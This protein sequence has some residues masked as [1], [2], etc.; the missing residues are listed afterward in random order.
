MDFKHSATYPH[1]FDDVLAASVSEEFLSGLTSIPDV[2]VPELRN[3]SDDGTT[4]TSETFWAYTGQLDTM[5]KAILGNNDLTWVQTVTIDKTTKSGTIDIVY[6]EGKVP[7]T[8][9]G[10]VT[11]AEDGGTTT[12]TIE[13]SLVVKILFAGPQVEKRLVEALGVRFDAETEALNTFLAK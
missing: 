6:M 2:A 1:S 12:R 5:A 3:V 4:V 10:T 8:C 7:G 13:G 11:Y 9:T